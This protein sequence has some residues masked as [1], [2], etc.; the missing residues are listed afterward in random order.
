MSIGPFDDESESIR[1]V[2]VSLEEQREDE[3]NTLK[4]RSLSDSKLIERD[5]SSYPEDQ[6][7][8]ALQR[9]KL[10]SLIAK[11]N[12]HGWSPTTLNPLISK[13]FE[14]CGLTKKP[15]SRTVCR[16]RAAFNESGG[17]IKS[18]V[19]RHH[20]KGSKEKKVVGD[21]KYFEEALER[22]LTS[23]RPSYAK[24]YE[25]YSDS[26]ILANETIVE[27]KISKL[28]YEGF[29]KRLKSLPPYMVAVGRY[30]QY[31]ADLWFRFFDAHEPPTRVLQRG[32]IDH[33]P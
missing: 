12:N 5:L 21:E 6:Q 1:N 9:Y 7:N 4:Y 33:T 20:D 18:L 22:F 11:D 15:S 3:H 27:G 24:A 28:T 2:Q 13:H 16:W 10:I 32:E 19:N 26:S 30:G 17:D 14:A 8:I 25:F 29:K 31:F 23:T